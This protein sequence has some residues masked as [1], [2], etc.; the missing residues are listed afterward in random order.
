MVA[1]HRS[2]IIVNKLSGSRSKFVHSHL[3]EENSLPESRRHH[4]LNKIYFL[5]APRPKPFRSTS[6]GAVKIRCRIP[7]D[8]RSFIVSY[9]DASK[10][11]T[12]PTELVVIKDSQSLHSFDYLSVPFATPRPFRIRNALCSYHQFPPLSSTNAG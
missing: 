8:I 11:K 5:L 9:E 3:H 6:K 2:N 10:E 12:A 7:R 4:S 1:P